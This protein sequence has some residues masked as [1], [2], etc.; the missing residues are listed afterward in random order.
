[1]NIRPKYIM[2]IIKFLLSIVLLSFI[3]NT[4]ASEIIRLTKNNLSLLPKGKEVDAMIGDWVMK[5]DKVVAV[6]ANAAFDREA[7][8]MVSSIQGAVIDFTTLAENNDQLTVFYPQGARVD[9]PSADTIIVLKATGNSVQLKAVKFATKAEPF[10]AET[11]YTL[12]D[13][14]AYLEVSTTYKNTSSAP[15]KITPYDMLRCDNNLEDITPP[16]ITNLA[17]IYNKWYNSAYGVLSPGKQL[18]TAPVSGKRNFITMGHRIYYNGTTEKPQDALDLAAGAQLSISRL[19][20]TGTNV[21]DLQS[22]Q[23]VIAPADLQKVPVGVKDEN[24]KLLKDAFVTARN[25]KTE[26]VSSALTAADGNAM[27]YLPGGEFKMSVTK[28]GHDTANMVYEVKAVN[29]KQSFTLKPETKINF[30][31]SDENGDFLPVK[32]SFTSLDTKK[33]INLGPGSRS[34]GTTNLYYANSREFTVPVPEGD[35][36]VVISHGPE[37]DAE[38]VVVKAVAGKEN[39]VNAKIRRAFSSPGYILA[40]LHNHTTRSGDSNAG[41]PDRVI[42]MVASGVEFAPA[43]EHNRISTYEGVIKELGLQK[44]I[45]SAAGMELSG[46][47]GPGETNHQIGFPLLIQ[48]DKRG[49]GAPKTD[50]DPYVQMGGLYNYDNGKFKLMQQN[51]PEISKLYFDKDGD[52]QADKG[53]GTEKFTDVMEIRETVHAL[54]E[55]LNGGNTNIRS[56]QWLQM[57]NLGYHIFGTANT[58]AH[59]VGNATGSIFNYVY[60]KHDIPE[61]IDAVEIAHQVKDGRVIM[62]N[63]PFMKVLIN[64]ELPGSNIKA[65]GGN[66]NVNIEILTAKWCKVNTVQLIING[67]A[68]STL[69]FTK[70]NNPAMFSN[71]VK[72]FKADITVKLKSDAHIIV[73]AY[74]QNETVGLVE[75]DNRLRPIALS[76]PVFVDVD[77][78][79]FT[80]NK[81]MLG[82][83]LPA[84]RAKRAAAGDESEQ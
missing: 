82:Q 17:F 54:P 19:L 32:V 16:G 22:Q 68:D 33:K 12:T 8:Q 70:A 52:G 30:S 25:S 26:L 27:L 24:G 35:Y 81:D 65:I 34:N 76:N 1:M 15:I 53:Y 13:G 11:I 60:T 69:K 14:K 38:V 41:V 23:L 5:N 18:Y 39:K 4:Y 59:A 31:V 21:A 73:L 49:Y 40:D 62:S 20:M 72:A 3:Q 83:P 36:K 7:N 71:T 55:A 57:L 2:K 43:T 45:T 84:K 48:P 77:G 6:I 51:H 29:Q 56:F 75:G 44:F 74:G 67:R 42:N 9:V 64:N 28:P 58:D 10:I 80:P 37:Y 66:V 47:P 78:N 79:G 63:G 50:K 46:R 61:K